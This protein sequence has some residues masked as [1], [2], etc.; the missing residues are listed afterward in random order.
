[1]NADPENDGQH[2]CQ[3]MVLFSM[4]DLFN[5]WTQR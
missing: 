1:V 5:G 3:I 2:L 4:N